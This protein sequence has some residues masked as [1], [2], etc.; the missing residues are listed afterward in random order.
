MPL[1]AA[2]RSG[3]Y[4]GRGRNYFRHGETSQEYADIVVA[5]DGNRSMMKSAKASP[6]KEKIIGMRM[7]ASWERAAM[8]RDRLL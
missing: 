7:S 4:Q 2:R 5:I 8:A 1:S 6:A 3:G